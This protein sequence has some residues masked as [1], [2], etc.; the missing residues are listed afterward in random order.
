MP[1]VEMAVKIPFEAEELATPNRLALETPLVFCRKM[2]PARLRK[3]GWSNNERKGS[4]TLTSIA[5]DRQ[6]FLGTCGT[7][8]S[9]VKRRL[10]IFR[11]W[12]FGRCCL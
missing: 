9:L 12:Y 6:R 11:S 4:G 2:S 3:L 8:V 7:D 5:S 1:R 10:A